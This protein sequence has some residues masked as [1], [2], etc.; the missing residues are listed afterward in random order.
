MS[1]LI[2]TNLEIDDWFK[3]LEDKISVTVSDP[4]YPFDSQN[5]TN[6]YAGM[7]KRFDW[8]KMEDVFKQIYAHTQE[9]GRVYIFCNRDG[10]FKTQTLLVKSG[11]EFRNILVWDKK[12][13]GGGYHWRSQVEYIVYVSKGEPK[14]YVKGAPN[15]FSYPR[16]SKKDAIP[17][18]GYDPVCLSAKPM[19]IWKDILT[20]GAVDGDIVADPFAGSNPMKAAIETEVKLQNKIL[21][22]YTNTY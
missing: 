20:H 10:L 13:F 7:Y 18:I 15:I 6:R 14:T 5:G 9:Q 1:T 11:F 3:Q 2:H 4:P 8:A 17:S 19:Q 12:H 21:K 22:A 16:P